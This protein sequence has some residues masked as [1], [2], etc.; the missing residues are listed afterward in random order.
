[1]VRYAQTTARESWTRLT[2]FQ[3]LYKRKPVTMIPA[4]A[5]IDNNTEVGTPSL[6]YLCLSPNLRV[7]Q[8]WVMPKSGEVFTD[9]ESYLSRYATS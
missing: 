9:Y 7:L 8:V 6:I 4:P 3:V 2:I 1:M 5:K